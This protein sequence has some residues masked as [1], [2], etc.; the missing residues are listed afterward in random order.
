MSGEDDDEALTWAGARDPSHYETPEPKPVK[1][2]KAKA[3][4]ATDADADLDVAQDDVKAPMSAVVLVCL[5]V[6]GGIYA[7]Y[8]IGWFVSWQRLAYPATT[9][10]LEVAAFHIQQVLGILAPPLWFVIT[11]LFTRDRKPAVR[12][13]WLV[14]GA[15]LLVPWS[16]T[17]GQ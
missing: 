3:A 4:T 12:L 6:L 5:G 14:V 10:V 7:L 2:S 16:F 11:L 8:T 1:G 17:F 15:L 13:L 9:D